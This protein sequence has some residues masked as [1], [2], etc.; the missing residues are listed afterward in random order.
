MRKNSSFGQRL[1]KWKLLELE[2]EKHLQRTETP[3]IPNKKI[4]LIGNQWIHED[5]KHNSACIV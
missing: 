5:K 2:R 3:Q 4:S 1:G